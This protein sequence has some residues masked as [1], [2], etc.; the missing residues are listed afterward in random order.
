MKTFIV[1]L[2]TL[3]MTMIVGCTGTGAAAPSTPASSESATLTGTVTY[4][5]RIAL[6]EGAVVTVQLVD[7]SLA[8]A[9]AT[10]LAKQTITTT[11]QVPIPFT[12]DYN[13]ADIQANHR[14]AVQARIE[15]DG[16]LE[17]IT[18]TNHAVL[19]NG[20]PTDTIEVIV[21]QVG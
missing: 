11:S 7:V 3:A 17:W 1:T 20:A 9:P 16:Q 15:V 13:S 18:T 19:T 2:M 5:Q 10:V 12:L 21:E 4:L 6:R 14:Y 8:D